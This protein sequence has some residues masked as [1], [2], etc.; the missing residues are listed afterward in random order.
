E[1]SGWQFT[2]FAV[3]DSKR[4]GIV[5]ALANRKGVKFI[6][7]SRA[8]F[9][10]ATHE[11]RAACSLSKRYEQRSSYPYWYA[12]HPQWNDFLSQGNDSYFVLGCMDLSVAYAI[13][14]KVLSSQL[15]ALNTTTTARSTYWH[16]HLVEDDASSHALLLPKKSSK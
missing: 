14:L 5:Q 8:L 7:K 11:T 15:S 12:Y 1:G 10:D 9:W 2:D 16:I 13:P 6:K 3:L 4:Q